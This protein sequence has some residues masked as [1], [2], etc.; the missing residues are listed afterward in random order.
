MIT[1]YGP[2]TFFL[3]LSPAEY[4]WKQLESFLRKINNDTENGKSV[5][6]LIA[7]DP[8]STSR[9]IDNDFKAKLE[10]ISADNGSLGKVKHYAWRREYQ[11]R[12]LQNFHII[13]W[14]DEAPII[15]KNSNEEVVNFIAKTIT[16][17]L[18]DK[19]KFPTLHERVINYQTHKD[20]SYCMRK[21]KLQLGQPLLVDL[22][23]LDQL[24][25]K[26]F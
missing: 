9:M 3:T 24:L 5:S 12:G 8:V 26:L 13:I 2:V 17:H 21:R 22:V 11:S 1:W 23:F 18:P 6:A 15:G 25:R 16:C 7:H 20:N 10:F 4:N 14:I 19:R